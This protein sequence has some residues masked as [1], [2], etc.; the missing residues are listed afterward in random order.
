MNIDGIFIGEKVMNIDA[1]MFIDGHSRRRKLNSEARGI[2][3]EGT[4]PEEE[5]TE[6]PREIE[7]E[8]ATREEEETETPREIEEEEATR[9]A[10][11][12]IVYL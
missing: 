8:E 6:T 9:K 3:E 10:E 5:E 1:N 2:E 11:E 12:T 4:T 7:E